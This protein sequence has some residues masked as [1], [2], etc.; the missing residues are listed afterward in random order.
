[1]LSMCSEGFTKDDNVVKINKHKGQA[2][3]DGL[4]NSLKLGWKVFDAKG[5]T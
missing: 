5:G 3:E 1:M 4:H 2:L